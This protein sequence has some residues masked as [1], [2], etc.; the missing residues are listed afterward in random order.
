MEKSKSSIWKAVTVILIAAGL[1][2]AYYNI[3]ESKYQGSE[4]RRQ[5]EAVAE[6]ILEAPRNSDRLECS[7]TICL[8]TEEERVQ[9]DACTIK[10]IHDFVHQRMQLEKGGAKEI[11][12]YSEE[13]QMMYSKGVSP[14]YVK[15]DGKLHKV[16]SDRWF[17]YQGEE[18]YGIG[19]RTGESDRISYGYLASADFLRKIREE[20]QDVIGDET[21]ERYTAVIK[22]TVKS[23]EKR[24]Q[25]DN[26]FRKVL[27]AEGLD[28]M[29]LRKEYPEVYDLLK[30]QYEKETEELTIWVDQEGKLRVIEKE[31]TFQYY[32]ALMKENSEKIQ[33]KA[34]RYGYPRVT[35]RQEYRYSPVCGNIQIPEKFEEI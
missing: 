7:S 25:G 30:E 5:L 26:E 20:G 21:C 2:Y 12:E 24:K 23:G 35:C 18:Q 13:G 9:D 17:H 15:K 31:Y 14:V 6:P 34:G 32:I 19:E 33:A 28:S 3:L 4:S 29:E 22:N 8:E 11:Y 27:S 16:P 1:F 10:L